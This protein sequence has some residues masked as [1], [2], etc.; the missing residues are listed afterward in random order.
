MR[1]SR[2]RGVTDVVRQHYN[3]VPERGREWRKTESKIKGL[4]SFRSSRPMRNSLRGLMIPRNGRMTV[5]G[6]RLSMTSGCWCWTWVVARAVTW[7]S[8][9]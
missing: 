1:L 7:A 2:D 8:G 6:P 9:S 4:R 5:R 3:A